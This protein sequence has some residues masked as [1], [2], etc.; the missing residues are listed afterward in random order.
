VI[1]DFAFFLRALW[2]EWRVLLTGGSIVAVL[3]LINL[4]GRSIPRKV[5]WSIIGITFILAAFRAWRNEWINAGRGFVE[6]DFA[7]VE[8]AFK[9]RT[10]AY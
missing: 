2:R 9:G 6:V 8:E 3:V 10:R 4:G 7:S 5:N 1:R